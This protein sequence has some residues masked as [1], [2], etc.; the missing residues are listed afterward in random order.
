MLFFRSATTLAFL[1]TAAVNAVDIDIDIDVDV[2]EPVE[3]QKTLC[4]DYDD[5]PP[6]DLGP[7]ECTVRK[8]NKVTK[9]L[10]DTAKDLNPGVKCKGGVKN[11]RMAMTATL[12]VEDAE[13][14][15][16]QMCKVQLAA[17]AEKLGTIENWDVAGVDLEEFYAGSGFL[18]NETGNFKQDAQKFLDKGGYDRY[19]VISDNPRTNDHYPTTEQSYAAG[20]AVKDF[21]SV[22]SKKNYFGAPTD[23]FECA[24][25]TAMCC[26]HRDRQY[27]D[28]NGNCGSTDCANQNPGDNTDLCWTEDSETDEVYPWPGDKTEGDLHCHGIS[29]GEDDD[30]GFDIN[31]KAKWNSLFYVSMYDHMYKRGYVGSITSD[32]K[33]A[34]SQ[35][36]CGC[37]EEMAP[38]ARADCNQVTGTT[39]YTLSI[40]NDMLTIEFVEETFELEFEAC[41]GYNYVEDFSPEDYE[42][43]LEKKELKSSNNDLSAFIFKQYLE[44]KIS[45]TEVGIV[46]KTLI[47]YRN[48]DVNKSD[49]NREEA[50][51]SAFEQKFPGKTYEER[52]V[53]DV[54]GGSI[55]A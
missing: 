21:Y 38:V 26:W 51:A 3:P 34:G 12:T 30:T 54:V 23:K 29:W 40:D 35:P 47:G 13:K 17:A 2:E 10:F 43:D 28:Q 48:P 39:N 44:G 20:Q 31:T 5:L 37:I 9:D 49:E 46:E 8:F 14:V 18:N 45:S 22:E 53:S 50:C 6:V 16:E 24:S 1:A 36:M 52:L 41:E 27:F 4:F 11:E 7:T 19:N 55:S 15:V 33:I 42:N 25:Y 32:P